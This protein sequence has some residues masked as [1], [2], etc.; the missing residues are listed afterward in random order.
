MS[1]VAAISIVVAMSCVAVERVNIE[2][3]DGIGVIGNEATRVP[4]GV[5]LTGAST[6]YN[7]A[8]ASKSGE[9]P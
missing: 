8:Q 9:E 5:R 7:T 2:P 1:Q 4:D 6:S 3:L